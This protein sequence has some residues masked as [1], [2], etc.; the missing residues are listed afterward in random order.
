VWSRRLPTRWLRAFVVLAVVMLLA[1][2]QVD[3]HVDVQVNEDGSGSVTVGAGFDDAALARVGNLDQ[4]LRTGD[5]EAAG[6]GVTAP[7]REGDRT[8][9]RASKTFATPAEGEAVLA[10]VTGPTGPFRDF[11][12]RVDDGTFGTEYAVQGTVD[13]TGGPQAFGDDELRS[14]LGGD[15]YG[16]TLTSLEQDEGRP[17]TE[18]VDFQVTVRVPGE[19]AVYAPSFADPEPTEISVS[20]SQ[21]SGL[22]SIAIWGLVAL[23]GVVALVVLR[24]GFRRVNR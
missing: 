1:S 2:C 12:L 19:T 24:Q 4:Q 9:V 16:G 23:V 11:A 22:A 13:L 20:S 8:W 17:A 3:L 10:E 7:T 15:A 21:R 18:M 6:W 5:L 14:L